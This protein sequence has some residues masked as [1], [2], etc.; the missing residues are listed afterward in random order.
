[1]WPEAKQNARWLEEGIDEV[2][3]SSLLLH[4][5]VYHSHHNNPA[6]N[7]TQL[8]EVGTAHNSM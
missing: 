6:N 2:L 7:P 8:M 1:M 4:A 5:K 3:S